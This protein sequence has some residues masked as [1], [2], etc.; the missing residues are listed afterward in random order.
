MTYLSRYEAKQ[1]DISQVFALLWCQHDVLSFQIT[2]PAAASDN[3]LSVNTNSFPAV[4]EVSKASYRM[5]L[6]LVNNNAIN[7]YDSG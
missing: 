7:N 2:P 5:P 4:T 1:M 3:K 6:I